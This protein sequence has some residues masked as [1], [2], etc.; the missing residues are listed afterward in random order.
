MFPTL[1][2]PD[3]IYHDPFSL[4]T[5]GPLWTSPCFEKLHRH[6]QGKNAEL[7]TYSCSTA[8]RVSLLVAG[9]AVAEGAATGVKTSTTMAFSRLDGPRQHPDQPAL[10]GKSWL[11]RWQRSHTKHA[12]AVGAEEQERCEKL[13]LGHGQFKDRLS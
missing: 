13:V 9:W 7:Y 6:L 4:H 3:L 10:L 2:A 1:P 5:D 8:V 12:G 11:G